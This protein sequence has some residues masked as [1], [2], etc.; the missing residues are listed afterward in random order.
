[1]VIFRQGSFGLCFIVG[2]GH[3]SGDTRERG[4]GREGKGEG[5]RKGERGWEV[6]IGIEPGG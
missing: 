1:M 6:K 5:G 4:G 2:T 3:N